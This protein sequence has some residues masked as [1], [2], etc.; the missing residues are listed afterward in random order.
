MKIVKHPDF[1]KSLDGILDFIAEDS[2]NQAI[3]F[4]QDLEEKL[5]NITY[6]FMYRQS[7]FYDDENV[8]DMIFKGYV[9]PYFI[10]KVQEKIVILDIFKY[11]DKKEVKR[12]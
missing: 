10:D 4:N 3:M 6:P 1:G 5:Q 7:C 2:L 8:R 12:Q 11:I 9:I